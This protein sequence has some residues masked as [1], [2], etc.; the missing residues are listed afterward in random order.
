M[1]KVP[2]EPVRLPGFGKVIDARIAPARGDAEHHHVVFH[3][4]QQRV[5]R[6]F[7]H[8]IAA[9]AE[10]V[11]HHAVAVEGLQQHQPAALQLNNHRQRLG[12]PA[13]ALLWHDAHLQAH[14]AAHAI[15]TLGEG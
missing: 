5:Q 10:P 2:P 1:T 3:A 7:A 15:E 11:A 6:L 8:Q 12:A 13:H 14:Q 9:F 4:L